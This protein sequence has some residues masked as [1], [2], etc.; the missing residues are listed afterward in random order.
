MTNVGIPVRGKINLSEVNAAVLADPEAFFRSCNEKYEEK[1]RLIARRVKENIDSVRIILLSGPSSSAKTTTSL[2][3]QQ[4]LQK[5]G[6]NAL[7]VSMDDFFR[8]RNDVPDLPS[9]EPDFESLHALD[10]DFFRECMTKLVQDGGTGL[11]KFN[12]KKGERDPELRQVKVDKGTVA[13][14]EGI[15]ALDTEIT[16]TLPQQSLF[17]LYVSLSSDFISAD[18]NV[19]L[20]ARQARLMRRTIRDFRFRGNSPEF[21]LSIWDGVCRGE[22]EYI[23]PFKK[24]A[25][26][27]VNSVFSCEPCLFKP[28]ATRLF[29]MIEAGSKQFE[30]AQTIL[31][32]LENFET[33]PMSMAPADCVLREFVGGSVYYNKS[34]GKK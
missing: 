22:D 29:G 34:A 16:E 19:L 5:H 32:A 18:G 31:Q 9:G 21:T 12:F 27:T 4:E 3:I 33:M 2:K 11:P 1:I 28:E 15:H 25:D 23:R 13:I 10:T 20:S 24:Y 7:T 17:K 30:K 14:V 6:I 8:N 26:M